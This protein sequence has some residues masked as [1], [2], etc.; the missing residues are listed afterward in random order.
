MKAVC[1]LVLAGLLSGLGGCRYVVQD[2]PP[3][4]VRPGAVLRLNTPIEFPADSV[5]VYI[6][7]GVLIAGNSVDSYKPYCILE[8]RHKA[9]YPVTVRP[10]TFVV[11][12]TYYES[13]ALL[14]FPLFAAIAPVAASASVS[15]LV[16]ETELFLHS[17]RQPNV[18]R[19]SCKHWVDPAFARYVSITEI[20]AALGSLMSIGM[21][22]SR[23]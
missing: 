6:Q 13:T 11:S 12:R 4:R 7:H 2:A 23:D 9:D 3:Y 16:Y 14:R 18:Y 20:A 15:H 22:V 5:A 1:F 10:D 21:S 8:L 19:L 17:D